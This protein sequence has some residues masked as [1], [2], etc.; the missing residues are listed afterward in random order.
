MMHLTYFTQEN[1]KL[2]LN[3]M[4]KSLVLFYSS[5]RIVL[6]MTADAKPN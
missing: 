5:V 6:Q 1:G 2:N 3:R 4:E